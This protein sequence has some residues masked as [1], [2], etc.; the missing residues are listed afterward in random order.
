MQANGRFT[1]ALIGIG[2]IGAYCSSSRS[3]S[4]TA[5]DHGIRVWKI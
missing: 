4:Q 5:D 2:V 3:S 1:D